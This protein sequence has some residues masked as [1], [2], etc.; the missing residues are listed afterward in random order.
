MKS[1]MKATINVDRFD[2]DMRLREKVSKNSESFTLGLNEQL[3]GLVSQEPRSVFPAIVCSL[4]KGL[5]DPKGG[6]QC[7]HLETPF[8]FQ[9]GGVTACNPKQ[10]GSASYYINFTPGYSGIVIGTN[11]TAV[12]SDDKALGNLALSTE[13]SGLSEFMWEDSVIG[14][15]IA[16]AWCY[17]AALD[18]FWVVFAGT[19]VTI[20]ALNKITGAATGTVVTTNFDEATTGNM[21][22]MACDANH[23]FITGTGTPDTRKVDKATGLV[24][25]TVNLSAIFT[26]TNMSQCGLDGADFWV[27]CTTQIGQFNKANFATIGIWTRPGVSNTTN[28][29]LIIRGNRI[30]YGAYHNATQT[31][32]IVLEDKA[33]PDTGA[34]YLAPALGNDLNG[35]YT[36]SAVD[37]EDGYIYILS[38]HRRFWPSIPWVMSRKRPWDYQDNGRLI[39]HEECRMISATS[40]A[41]GGEFRLVRDFYNIGV[42]QNINE[43]G[44][45]AHHQDWGF[46][47]IARDV[48][49]APIAFDA[50]EMLRIAYDIEFLV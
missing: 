49:A 31:R 10:T 47:M 19:P 20:V 32:A 48:L 39:I 6:T 9:G 3:Y 25:D 44:I 7:W 26:G 22:S 1:R 42:L 4:Q 18:C 13:G 12:S 40:D 45:Y 5:S 43:I 35:S 28:G 34:W 2:K 38:R 24:V 8:G 37:G 36:Y 17:D 11:N 21:R 29:G 15:G 41:F 23:F 30:A 50:G 16:R 14:E 27:G 33:N 46:Y